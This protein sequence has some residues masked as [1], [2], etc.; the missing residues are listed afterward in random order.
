MQKG[1]VV[2]CKRNKLKKNLHRT[3]VEYGSHNAERKINKNRDLLIKKMLG[4]E[5]SITI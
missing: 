4:S 3:N 5:Q 2:G 1:M